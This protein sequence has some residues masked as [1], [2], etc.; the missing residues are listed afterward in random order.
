[1]KRVF[2]VRLLHKG[3]NTTL[4]ISSGALDAVL[5]MAGRMLCADELDSFSVQSHSVTSGRKGGE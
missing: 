3:S 5:D 4:R 1:M 2:T